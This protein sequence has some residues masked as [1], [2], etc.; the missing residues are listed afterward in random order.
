MLSKNVR[1]AIIK[2]KLR[3]NE[4]YMSLPLHRRKKIY[5]ESLVKAGL[6]KRERKVDIWE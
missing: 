5:H 1:K 3:R 4:W 6:A 2:S